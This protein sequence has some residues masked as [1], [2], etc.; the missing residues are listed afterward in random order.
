M[1]I[2]EIRLELEEAIR[3]GKIARNNQKRSFDAARELAKEL[4]AKRQSQLVS[5]KT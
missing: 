5:R 1:F 3:N 2:G 4:E